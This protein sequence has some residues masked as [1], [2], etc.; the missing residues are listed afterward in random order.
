MVTRA[1]GFRAKTRFALQKRARDRGKIAITCMMQEFK[2]GDRVIITQNSAVHKAMP[3]PRYKARTGTVIGKQGR[4]YKVH[5]VDG[6]K[7]KI[8]LSAPVHLTKFR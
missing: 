4:S 1:G 8:L 5:I 3:H 6:G 7:D 2:I